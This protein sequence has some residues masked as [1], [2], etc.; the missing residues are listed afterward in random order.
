MFG[1]LCGSVVKSLLANA[2]Q[3]LNHQ[4]EKISG[5]RATKPVVPQLLSVM[6]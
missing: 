6:L 2:G 1:F 3:G 5:H 4:P